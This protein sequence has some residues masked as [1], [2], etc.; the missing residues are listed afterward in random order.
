METHCAAAMRASGEKV[1]A[2]NTFY[3]GLLGEIDREALVRLAGER[4]L[5]CEIGF[6]PGWWVT[7]RKTTG[8]KV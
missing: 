1:T 4:G 5:A 2:S 6:G 3:R 7:M 8:V